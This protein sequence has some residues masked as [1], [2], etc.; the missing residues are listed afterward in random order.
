MKYTN[1]VDRMQSFCVLN[2]V[3]H[4][5]PL[6]LKVSMI[7]TGPHQIILLLSKIN[8]DV[9]VHI[10]SQ[11]PLPN[12]RPK[13]QKFTAISAT[14]RPLSR[15]LRRLLSNVH[16]VR[17]FKSNLLKMIR[18]KHDFLV[19]LYSAKNEYSDAYIYIYIKHYLSRHYFTKI[20]KNKEFYLLGY[21]AV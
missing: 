18:W 6:G 15:A 3:V 14:Y 11:T 19:L 9:N 7:S 12:C 17:N 2:Q 8:W 13:A 4:M 1:S 10:I 16:Y 21:N 20:I 5:E